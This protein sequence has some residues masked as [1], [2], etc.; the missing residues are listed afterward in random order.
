VLS[1]KIIFAVTLALSLP[2]QKHDVEISIVNQDKN[3]SVVDELFHDTLYK[4][5]VNGI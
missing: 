5:I 1:N 2:S 4:G 3:A